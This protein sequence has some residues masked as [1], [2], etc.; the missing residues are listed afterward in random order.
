[1]AICIYAIVAA[2]PPCFDIIF[3]V[4]NSFASLQYTP[5][6]TTQHNFDGQSVNQQLH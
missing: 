2:Q 6:C 1:M 3:D 4:I 5:L